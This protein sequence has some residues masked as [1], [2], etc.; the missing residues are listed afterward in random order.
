MTAIIVKGTAHVIGSVKSFNLFNGKSVL[1]V[2]QDGKIYYRVQGL[3][4]LVELE[5][6]SVVKTYDGF[7]ESVMKLINSK[8]EILPPKF[9]PASHQAEGSLPPHIKVGDIFTGHSINGEKVSFYETVTI[10]GAV[11]NCTKEGEVS[12]VG[13]TYDWYDDKGLLT[14]KQV[15]PERF[16]GLVFRGGKVIGRYFMGAWEP[17]P[18]V[19]KRQQQR[20]NASANK[21]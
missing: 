6:G 8:W 1:A 15:V 10:K 12:S 11:I 14:T 2:K 18:T 3:D 19:G 13:L 16:T 17:T 7:K 9:D 4:K 21:G 5:E 20:R